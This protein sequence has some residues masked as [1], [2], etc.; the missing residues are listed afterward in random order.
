MRFFRRGVSEIIW[1]PAVADIN[2]PTRA[3][4]N[5]GTP[6]TPEVADV[7]G[8]ELTNAP[9]ATP[10]LQDTFTSQ[11]DG[12]DTVA[13]SSLIFYDDEAGGGVS[14]DIRTALAKGTSGF[15]ILMPY[16]DVAGRRCEVWA[17]KSTGVNDEWS[18]GTD[19]ARFSIGFAMSQ[20]PAQNATIPA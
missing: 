9:I 11:I 7:N 20:R 6:L 1:A 18:L 17:T 4:I 15:A 13:D 2:N 19:A 5:A 8:F 12:E 16:G 14:G 10:D 3:E